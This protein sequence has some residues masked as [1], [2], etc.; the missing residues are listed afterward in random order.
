MDMTRLAEPQRLGDELDRIRWR[1]ARAGWSLL[2]VPATAVAA[3]IVWY[4]TGKDASLFAVVALGLMAAALGIA[5]ESR[6]PRCGRKFFRRRVLKRFY[7]RADLF[8][9]S[10]VNC[11]LTWT[12]AGK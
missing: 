3:G 10:C 9:T 8:R 1:R 12:D 4:L 5:G 2:L 6:C 7:G 11:G